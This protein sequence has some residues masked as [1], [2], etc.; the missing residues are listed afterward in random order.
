M[1]QKV[2]LESWILEFKGMQAHQYVIS[3][4]RGKGL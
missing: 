2:A 4:L 1:Q 3:L